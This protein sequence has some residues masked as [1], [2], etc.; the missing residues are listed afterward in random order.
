MSDR[1]IGI[2]VTTTVLAFV[3]A[4]LAVEA[5]ERHAHR[6]SIACRSRS[7]SSRRYRRRTPIARPGWL[8]PV[9]EIATRIVA[10]VSIVCA[11]IAVTVPASL[12]EVWA[13]APSG[14]TTT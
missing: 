3:L 14:D 4:A 12:F 6:G 7:P 9:R 2:A 13:V 5:L 10:I 1:R 11:S 8:H